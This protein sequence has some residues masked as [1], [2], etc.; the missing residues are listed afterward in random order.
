[1]TMN[2]EELV[3]NI[4]YGNT[5]MPLYCLSGYDLNKIE[6]V[7]QVYPGKLTFTIYIKADKSYEFGPFYSCFAAVK[8][9]QTRLKAMVPSY[10]PWSGS[11][12]DWCVTDS[13]TMDCEVF[14][15]VEAKLT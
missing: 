1:M 6:K 14:G 2:F 3:K 13:R 9:F 15:Y 10:K 7:I 4:F 8:E 12:A 11:L 5:T